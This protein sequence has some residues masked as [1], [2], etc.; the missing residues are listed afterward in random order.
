VPSDWGEDLLSQL[1]QTKVQTW[2]VQILALLPPAD[3]KDTFSVAAIIVFIHP[4][5]ETRNP[6]VV[7]WR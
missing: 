1:G 2:S 6:S 7:G 3:G 4:I 5:I